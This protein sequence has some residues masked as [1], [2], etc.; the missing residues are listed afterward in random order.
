[1]IQRHDA[2][3]QGRDF[4]VGDVHGQLALLQ[5][6]LAD[7]AVDMPRR[8]AEAIDD[9]ECGRCAEQ[10]LWIDVRRFAGQGEGE[11]EQPRE[12]LVSTEFHDRPA[13]TTGGEQEL[14]L[15]RS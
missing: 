9:L 10:A 13:T 7:D 4:F 2:N 14:R 11:L 12:R 1:M 8:A 15:V 5:A 3:H 6:E